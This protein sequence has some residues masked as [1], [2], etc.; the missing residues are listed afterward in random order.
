MPRLR[1]VL[2]VSIF[3]MIS[4]VTARAT[5]WCGSDVSIAVPSAHVL[6]C[7][8]GDGETLAEAGATITVQVIGDQGHPGGPGM[9]PGDLW[10]VGC[11]DAWTAMCSPIYSAIDADAPTDA[12]GMTTIGGAIRGGG[13]GTGLWVIVAGWP[14]TGEWFPC[15]DP[16]CL[17]ITVVSPDING[18]LL[19]DLI[20]F[21]LFAA[22]WPPLPYDPAL[23][24]DGDGVV[25]LVDFATF[26]EH[27]LHGCQ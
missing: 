8:L 10:V 18:D 5:Q 1:L 16:I 20:D 2:L 6:V 9:P 26:A 11:D 21:S 17:P 13:S 14:A 25:D 3:A 12:N 22:G 4:A 24:L 15:A 27:F 19:V 23:D 7:P